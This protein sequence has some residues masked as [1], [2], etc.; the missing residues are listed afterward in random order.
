MDLVSIIFIIISAGTLLI[1]TITARTG[2]QVYKDAQRLRRKEILFSLTDELDKA[3]T[4]EYAR[5]I[6]DDRVS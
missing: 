2:L 4:L 5:S 1:A 6:L 3:E